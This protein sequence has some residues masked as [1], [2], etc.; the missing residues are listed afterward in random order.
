MY[1]YFIFMDLDKGHDR[2]DRKTVANVECV[3]SERLLISNSKSIL[4]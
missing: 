1:N 2:V 4:G 3:C